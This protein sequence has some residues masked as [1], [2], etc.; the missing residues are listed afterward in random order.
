VGTW[1]HEPWDNDNAADW[2][3]DFF[4]DLKVDSLNEVFAV[5]EDDSDEF[6]AAC[7]VL[8]TLGRGYVW[9]AKRHK[10]L[11]SLLDRAIVR[12]EAMIKP[13]SEFLDEWNNSPQVVESVKWQIDELKARRA[14]IRG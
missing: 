8:Q 11:V 4:Q 10:D 9:P 2:Y 3:G 7:F 13:G 5:E 6:R 1:G 12:L 14:S